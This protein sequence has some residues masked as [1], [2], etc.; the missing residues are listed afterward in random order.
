VAIETCRFGYY[1]RWRSFPD[2]CDWSWQETRPS[3]FHRSYDSFPVFEGSY[4]YGATRVTPSW[5]GSMFEALMPAL[6]VPEES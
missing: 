6:F 1:G 4:P 2:S 5:G 3:G